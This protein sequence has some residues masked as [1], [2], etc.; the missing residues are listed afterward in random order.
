MA[1]A[2][3]SVKEYLRSTR[4]HLST[5]VVRI[6]DIAVWP[7]EPAEDVPTES[8]FIAV[9]ILS[10]DRMTPLRAKCEEYGHGGLENIWIIDPEA[11]ILYEYDN[12]FRDVKAFAIPEHNLTIAAAKIFA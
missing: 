5:E 10:G 9:E 7:R 6:P 8:L 4:I 1:K 11:K 2:L 3:V 12:C